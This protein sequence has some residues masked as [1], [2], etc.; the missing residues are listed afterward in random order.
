MAAIPGFLE[1]SG[2]YQ[3]P[4][5]GILEGFNQ[6]VKST[7]GILDTLSKKKELQMQAD[8]AQSKAIQDSLNWEIAKAQLGIGQAKAEPQIKLIGAQ[9]DLAEANA[10]RAR[11]DAQRLLNAKNKKEESAAESAYSVASAKKFVDEVDKATINADE[12]GKIVGNIDSFTENYPKMPSYAKGVGAKV[13]GTATF[14]NL[15]S[16]TSKTNAEQSAAVIAANKD[17][18]RLVQNL[19]QQM[20][21][22]RATKAQL[23]IVERSTLTPEMTQAGVDKVAPVLRVSAQLVQERPKFLSAAHDVGLY[24]LSKVNSLWQQYQN[25]Y[26]VIDSKGIAHPENLD[27]WDE[28][29]YGKQSTG[30]KEQAKET[31]IKV[32]QTEKTTT[33]PKGLTE[34]NISYYQKEYGWSR[35]QIIAKYE[36]KN[37]K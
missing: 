33:L 3:A 19:L 31:Q 16:G 36:A 30:Q 2:Q 14:A 15:I 35:D 10:Q 23:D 6:G 29:I 28:F 22:S 7:S 26:P 5:S 32:P 9:T 27:K 37:G 24:D 25:K 13:T 1:A 18:A 4:N 8:E 20:R 21:N 12:A 34:E 17:S 11:A